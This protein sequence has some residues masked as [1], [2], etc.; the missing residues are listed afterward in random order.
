MRDG[1][2]RRGQKILYAWAKNAPPLDLPAGV[3]VAIGDEAQGP[4]FLSLQVHYSHPF[5]G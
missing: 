3:G 1:P 4:A 2:C 5:D